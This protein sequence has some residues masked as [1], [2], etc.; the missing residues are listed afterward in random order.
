MRTRWTRTL[1]VL[2]QAE[3]DGRSS[4]LEPEVYEILKDAGLATPRRVFVPVGKAPGRQELRALGT[5]EAVV[6]VV[7]PLIIHKSDVGGVAVCKAEPAAVRKTCAAMLKT[8]V[9][10]SRAAER[11]AVRESIR[12]FLVVEK[13]A[14]DNVGFGSEILFGLRRSPDFGSVLTVGS[15]GLDVEYMNARLKEGR[16]V[17]IASAHLLEDEQAPALLEPL[18]FYGKLAAEFRGRRPLVAPRVLAEALLRFRDLAAAFSADST[19]TPFVLEEA[20][21]N[22]FVVRRGRLVPLDGVCRFSRNKVV[23]SARPVEAVGRLLKPAS[24]GIIGVSE[25]MNIGHVIL[26]NILKGGFPPAA[27]TVVKP[28]LEA[29]EGCRCVPSIADMPETVDMFVLTLGADQCPG[30]IEDLVKLGKARSIILIAGGMGEKEGGASIEDRIRGLLAEGRASGRVTP[31]INGGN[32]LGVVSKPGLYDTLF[33]P[34]YKLPRPKEAGSASAMISQSGAFMI[35]RMSKMPSIEPLY[36]VSLGNQLDLTVSDYLNYLKDDPAVR[37][38]SVYMEGF[39][40]GDG[41]AFARAIR[42][43][44]ATGR[45]VLVYKAG[46]SPEGRS[47]TSSHT[48]S[49]AGDYGV[50]KALCEQAGAIV[51]GSLAEFEG[52]M[53][54]LAWLEGRP[55]R[56]RRVGLASNAGFECVMMADNLKDGAGLDLAAFAPETKERIL[57]S[58]R[59]LGID[60]LLDIHNPLDVTPVADDAAFMDS[61]QAFIGDPGV[62]CAVISNVP[63]SKALQTLPAGEGHAEDLTR[64]GGFAARTIEIFRS[65]DKPVV[66]NID[67]GPL[68]DPLAAHLEAARIPVFRRA[69]EALGFLRTYVDRLSRRG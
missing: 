30:V 38:F 59:P 26:N 2:E 5:A 8:V 28:G 52:F 10:R 63:L 20:E 4:L 6:K 35:C 49:V 3:K 50:F 23:P 44:T 56:G 54:G 32:C 18:A 40:P 51:A 67:A 60:K 9:A 12:G 16:A 42:E 37:T 55:V 34:G 11:R 68:Y 25:K 47:A 31:A 48:A 45:T 46:R 41:L 65:T 22:P 58:L 57:V 43:I 27:V 19:E 24:I 21:V 36:S 17:A 33:I 7:S 64:P 39:K 1:R 13:V 14:F 66:V 29:I 69:D 53:K 15:G 61:V 62:D